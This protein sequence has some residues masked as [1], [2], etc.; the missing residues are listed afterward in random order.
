M[1][2]VLGEVASGDV[3][4]GGLQQA[5]AGPQEVVVHVLRCSGG[6]EPDLA[7]EQPGISQICPRLDDQSYSVSLRERPVVASP[8]LE[9]ARAER[10]SVLA[11]QQVIG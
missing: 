5:Q 7:E 8:F 4:V 3:D 2:F 9:T 1:W 11:G 10:E 6:V